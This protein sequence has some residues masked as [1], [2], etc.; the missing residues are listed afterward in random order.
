[1]HAFKG[2]AAAGAVLLIL[3]GCAGTASP[4]RSA[5]QEEAVVVVECV[6]QREGRMSDCA[7][8]SE[9]PPG[10]G[11]GEAA[12]GGARQSRV[13]MSDTPRARAGETVRFSVRFRADR[14][15]HP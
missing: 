9:E 11:F 13:S 5:S 8:V 3:A 14:P 2:M 10:L 15:P 12:L 7:V 4:H 6:L 1:M